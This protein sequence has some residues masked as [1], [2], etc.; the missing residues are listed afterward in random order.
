MFIL[1][2]LVFLIKDILKGLAS[3][4][5]PIIVIIIGAGITTWGMMIGS[6]F[7]FFT[8][9]ILIAAG[10]IWGLLLFFYHDAFTLF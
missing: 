6:S 8:G 2:E 5:P 7:V 1:K 4:I 3:F 10:I 9:I